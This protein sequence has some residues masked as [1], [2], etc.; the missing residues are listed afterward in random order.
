[1][2]SQGP[3]DSQLL[4]VNEQPTQERLTGTFLNCPFECNSL[5]YFCDKYFHVKRFEPC[6]SA[7]EPSPAKC[8]TPWRHSMNELDGSFFGLPKLDLKRMLVPADCMC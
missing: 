6:S 1:M 2:D 7:T 5:T 3:D 8:L 4:N